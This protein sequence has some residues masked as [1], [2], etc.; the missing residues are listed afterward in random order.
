MAVRETS[1]LTSV[2]IDAGDSVSLPELSSLLSSFLPSFLPSFL[3]FLLSQQPTRLY[4]YWLAFI[5]HRDP[6]AIGPPLPCC[7]HRV[8]MVGSE[9]VEMRDLSPL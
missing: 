6:A 7:S 5:P 9:I 4:N 8:G 2:S 1:H 3:S